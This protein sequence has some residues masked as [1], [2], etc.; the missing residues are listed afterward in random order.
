MITPNAI[1][2]DMD[3]VLLDTETIC[4]LTWEMAAKEFNIENPIEAINLCRGTNPGDTVLIL[5][6]LYGESFPG[7]SFFDKT[8]EYFHQ[9]EFTKGLPLMPFAKE[10]LEYLKPKYKIGLASSTR[11]TS[12]RRQL[13]NAGLIDFFDVCITGDMVQHSKPSPDIYSMACKALNE[14][15]ENCVAIEDSPNGIKS[16]FAA[17]MKT[18]M[19]PDKI[20]CSDEILKICD[21]VLENLKELTKIF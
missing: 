9:I 16:A 13:T 7:E 11:G 20:P 6:Q 21:K 15:P 2:F 3:G 18:I 19:I 14:L 17:G 10:T 5:K 12:V 8:S 1:I 4:D